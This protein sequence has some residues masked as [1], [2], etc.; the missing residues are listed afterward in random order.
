VRDSNASRTAGPGLATAVSWLLL[1][2]SFLILAGWQFRIPALKG[3]MFSTFVAPNTVLLLIIAV[4]SV[5]LQSRESVAGRRLGITLGAIV[6][7]FAS[8]IVAE[9][10]LNFETGLAKLFFAHR[11]DDWSVAAPVGR[12]A[13]PTAIGLVLAGISLVT[14]RSRSLIS[15]LAAA[16]VCA[17][18]YLALVGYV[19]DVRDLYG[20]VMALPTA[21]FLL[22]LSVLLFCASER[23][24]L[25][26]LVGSK[27]AGSLLWRRIGPALALAIPVLGFLK[28]YAQQ[29]HYVS[30]ELGAAL[31]VVVVVFAF[32]FILLNTAREL[33]ALDAE[34]RAAMETLVRNEKFAATGRLAATVAHEINNPLEAA[35]NLIYLASSGGGAS[36]ET[37]RLLQ[38][39]DREL[40][41]VAHI[42]RQTLGFYRGDSAPERVALQQ[43]VLDVRELLA[44]KI[45]EAGVTVTQS[46][47]ECYAWADPNELRQIISN[48]L[49][50]AVDATSSAPTRHIEVS[51]AADGNHEVM[52][53]VIDTGRGIAT[54]DSARLFEPF[55]S[56]KPSHGTG[57]GLYVT[58]QL[59]EKN[60]GS[61]RLETQRREPGLRTVATITLPAAS[62]QGREAAAS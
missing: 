42:T 38:M 34:R 46:G 25:L 24:W 33:N 35:T 12:I 40:R 19:F 45:S 7:L 53:A 61:I 55:Y 47:D 9:H 48:L 14:L 39:A 5:K 26:S 30:L 56:T 59:V 2:G 44:R 17:V 22:L 3:A 37:Q 11:L 20:R 54:E 23:Q 58:K 1:I 8:V 29:N 62:E 13:F 51:L 6:C 27:Q 15:E 31:F 32:T 49:S 28:L 16:G 50:N 57:L 21:V 43:M 4:L 18:S 36:M 41:R 10:L 60:R 52:L